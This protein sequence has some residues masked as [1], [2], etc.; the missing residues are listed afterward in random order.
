MK[1]IVMMFAVVVLLPLGSAVAQEGYDFEYVL[2]AFAYHLVGVDENL[3][4]SEVYISNPSSVPANVRLGEFMPG[5]MVIPEPCLPPQG[6]PREVPPFTTIVWPAREVAFEMG[7]ATEM[8]GGLTFVADRELSIISRMVNEVASDPPLQE[9]FIPGFGLEIPAPGA[10][11]ATA[12]GERLMLPALV[13]HPQ[14]CA[15]PTFETSIGFVNLEDRRVTITLSFPGEDRPDYVFINHR[16]VSDTMQISV[17][18]R[19]WKQVTFG[20]PLGDGPGECKPAEVFDLVVDPDGA[21]IGY[22]TVVDRSTQDGRLVTPVP[23]TE[24]SVGGAD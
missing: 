16:P 6:L 21:V 11:T 18:A 20:P 14:A 2:P 8:V 19:G 4:S 15:D 23:I 7:C 5:R 3:W 13:W 12:P 10:D 22:G 24:D 1:K 9:G 17:R